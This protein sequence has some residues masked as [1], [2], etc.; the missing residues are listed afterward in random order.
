MKGIPRIISEEECALFNRLRDKY[1]DKVFSY[2]ELLTLFMQHFINPQELL[3]RFIKYKFPVI[4][5]LEKGKYKF[6][7]KPVYIQVLQNAWEYK[8]PKKEESVSFSKSLE[9]E[10]DDAILLLSENGYKVLKKILDAEE[11]L[12]NPNEPVSSFIHWEEVI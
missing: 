3:N 11:A 10:I 9:E 5:R 6:P 7:E 4:I 8:A 1:K 12:R 2:K